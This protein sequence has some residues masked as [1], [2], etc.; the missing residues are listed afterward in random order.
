MLRDSDVEPFG[1]EELRAAGLEN[2]VKEPFDSYQVLTG[3]DGVRLHLVLGQSVYT[4]SKLLVLP[5]VLDRT[6]G[7]RDF[8]YGVF[9]AV[10]FWHQLAFVPVQD[11]VAVASLQVLVGLA[12]RGFDEGVGAISPFVH[13]WRDGQLTQVS[14]AGEQGELVVRP[15]GELL[16]ILESLE[17]PPG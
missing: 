2:L 16:D 12:A 6:L 11:L 15:D 14:F 17:P 5:D 1:V 3:D 10:P 9:V 8:P 13:W 4:A 7:S